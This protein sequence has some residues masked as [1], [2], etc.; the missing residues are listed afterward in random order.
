MSSRWVE[1]PAHARE[2]S[3]GRL[4]A[5]FRAAA[6]AAGLKPSGGLD[7]GLLVCDAE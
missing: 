4:P 2:A 1:T 3:D 6:A 5:G 7:V